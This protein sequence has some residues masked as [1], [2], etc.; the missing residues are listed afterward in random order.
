MEKG[1]PLG[2]AARKLREGE[3]ADTS[4]QSVRQSL[5]DKHPQR[6]LPQ[7]LEA[8]VP[9]LQATGEDF[10]KALAHLERNRGS[11]AGPSG[12]TGEHLLAA[13]RASDDARGALLKVVNLMLSGKLPHSDALLDSLLI[14]IAKPDGT[15][16]PIA[17][18]EALYRLAGQVALVL[19]DGIGV[20]LAPQQLGV[21]IPDGVQAAGLAVRAAL[22]EDP[23]AM[24]LSLDVEN[25]FNSLCRDAMFAGWQRFAPGL[26]PFIQWAYGRATNLHIVGAPAGTLPIPSTAGSRQ[27]DPTG[28]ISAAFVL[29]PV[30][31]RVAAAS[32]DSLQFAIADDVTI[33]GRTAA[34]RLAWQCASGQ[35]GLPSAKCRL[36]RRKSVLFG[37]DREAAAQLAQ[38]FGVAHAPA[39]VVIAGTPVGTR[40]FVAEVVARRADAIVAD[41][42]AL[43]QLPMRAQVQWLLLRSS[44]SRKMAHLMRVVPWVALSN[45][46][47]RVER[48][49]HKAATAILALPAS[50]EGLPA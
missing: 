38:E 10:D 29:K 30:Q 37:N 40:A 4:K 50:P 19:L 43:T 33:V 16:R 35:Q 1:G 12:M 42:E 22:L 48:A 41:C 25:F 31:E 24:A 9:A 15:A 21:G 26:L 34:L 2:R 45:G 7:L 3:L 5:W 23:E 27:G 17:I 20:E 36:Q 11:A 14:G 8:T 28:S 39:G 44:L 13:A 47:S 6:P 18:G 46:M 32:P 49:V